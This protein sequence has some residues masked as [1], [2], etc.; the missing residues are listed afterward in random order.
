M[1]AGAQGAGSV[2]A[3]RALAIDARSACHQVTAD[4]KPRPPVF[5]PKEYAN[6]AA[7]AFSAISLKYAERPWALRRF[8]L[9][10]VHPMPE[11]NWDPAD[12]TAV[13]V[14]IQSLRHA[15]PPGRGG[16]RR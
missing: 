3:G 15:T 10:P 14:F 12:L 11:Q 4:Q 5:N 6:V 9:N 2:R 1:V 16:P 7:P 8:I 13:V